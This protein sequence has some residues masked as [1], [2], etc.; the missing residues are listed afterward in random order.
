MV[1]EVINV[2]E[3]M[4]ET[5]MRYDSIERGQGAMKGS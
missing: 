1:L 2:W 3:H 5:R 4:K